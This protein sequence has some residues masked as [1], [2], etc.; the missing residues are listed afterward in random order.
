MGI[1]LEHQPSPGV[2][3]MAAYATGRGKA[4]QRQRKDLLDFYRDEANRR[5]RRQAQFRSFTYRGALEGMRQQ[6]LGER[7]EQKQE[8]DL[9]AAAE[10]REWD[11][12]DAARDRQQAIDDRKAGEVAAIGLEETRQQGRQD[13]DKAQAEIGIDVDIREGLRK[14]DYEFEDDVDAG[15][16]GMTRKMLNAARRAKA[17]AKMDPNYT[18]EQRAELLSMIEAEERKILRMAKPKP[19]SSLD[20]DFAQNTKVEGGIRYGRNKSG[21][22]K[23]LA[24]EGAEAKEGAARLEKEVLRI[25]AASKT[26]MTYAKAISKAQENIKA[27]DDAGPRVPP[28]PGESLR[29]VDPGRYDAAGDTSLRGVDPDAYDAA[30]Q[31]GNFT[32]EESGQLEQMTSGVPDSLDAGDA[33]VTRAGE[34]SVLMAEQQAKDL[35]DKKKSGI[36]LTDDDLRSL[37]KALDV[38]RKGEKAI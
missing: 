11:L 27:L 19:R 1:R 3:G 9:E 25:M 22:W 24:D 37:Q 20:D 8:W 23:K 21:E 30:G 32:A 17:Q 36:K 13:R 4:R 29:G 33:P 16:N 6:G 15:G 34:I 12:E 26:G 31:G 2:I 28:A 14:G 18:D 10:G 35:I 7:A 5:E 38:L